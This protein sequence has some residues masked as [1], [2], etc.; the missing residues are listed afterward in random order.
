MLFV[1][2]PGS[3]CLG[4][5]ETAGTATEIGT[6]RRWL[7]SWPG[8]GAVGGGMVH[9][10]YYPTGTEHSATSA[11]GKAWERTRRATQRAA[12]EALRS[13]E[14]LHG[15]TAGPSGSGR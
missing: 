4:R 12:W 3:R 10:G 13:D 15:A 14:L 8:I 5:A 7:D 11:T 1:K 6:P 9:Q 2:S